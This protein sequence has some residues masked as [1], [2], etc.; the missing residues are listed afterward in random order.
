MGN[1]KKRRNNFIIQGGILAIASLLSRVI[2]L[3]YRIPLTNIIGD[4]GNGIYA[5][6]YNVYNIILLLSSYS[7][8]LAVSKLVSVR[9][10]KKEQKNA[11]RIYRGAMTFA[12]VVG[13]IAALITF[14]GADYL[15]D[16]LLKSPMS[17]L[18]LQ[19]LAPAVFLVAVMGVMRGYF[20]GVGS[21]VP[22]A[23]S[24][25]LE[26][27]FNAVI[28]IV[29]AY[30]LFE[31]GEKV[32]AL[33]RQP[34]YAAA[35]GAA[36]GTLGTSAGALIGLFFLIF[37]MQIYKPTMRR[38]RH[39]DKTSRVE[40]WG[41]VYSA[42]FLTIVPVL[43]STTIYNISSIVDQGVFNHIMAFQGYT[44]KAYNSLYGIYSM[45]YKV[46]SNVPIALASAMAASSVPS[47]SAAF[48]AGNEPLVRTKIYSAVRV[49]MVLSIPC[50]VG[51]GILASPI[52]TMLLHDST[53]LAANLLR[54]GSISIVFY[55]L[56]TLT[57]GILQGINRMR[58]P[59]IHAAIALVLHVA[60]FV[61]MILGFQ[62]NI[63]AMVYADVFFAIIM[64]ILNNFSIR[65]HIGYRQEFMKTFLVPLISAI[66]MGLVVWGS[67]QGIYKASGSN[68]IGTL[69]SICLGILVY[70]VVFLALKGM[71]REELEEMPLGRT[72]ARIAIKLHLIKP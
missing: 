16:N 62:W 65:K 34:S 57:N 35:Y 41:A 21:T 19:I 55:S 59:V 17:M 40:S 3:L 48:A 22:T 56:S 8:P 1:G 13:L 4:E 9:I 49:T 66:A 27:I 72:L 31:H 63:Y 14:F 18:S 42:L 45:K 15:T 36:G 43:L 54:I 64:C 26:Q 71:D 11:Q 33:L 28:S 6:A 53:P 7:L 12:F 52:L 70:F 23:V 61:I 32:A 10:G 67:Y 25:I 20:Q 46:L 5:S 24:Q 30:F 60:A 51:I 44:T 29:A 58:A 39:R 69:V 50:A 37:V 2:G 38:Q 68:T 47:V